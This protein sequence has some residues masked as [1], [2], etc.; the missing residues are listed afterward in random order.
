MKP[1]HPPS[2]KNIFHSLTL[3]L[4]FSVGLIVFLTVLGYAY[5]LLR[6]QENQALQKILS[7]AGMFSD[8]LRK[9]THY[10]MLKYQ[11][12]ALHK[13]IEAVGQ[14]SGVELIRIFNKKGA[15]MYSTRKQEVGQTVNMQAEA[16]YSCHQRD[17]ILERLPVNAR[18]RIFSSDNRGRVMGFINP[19]YNEASCSTAACHVHPADRTVLGVIDVVLSLSEVD[20]EIK[21]NSSNI[22]IF[23]LFFF[24][25]AFG[26]VGFCIFYFVDRPIGKLRLGTA[27]IASGDY[28]HPIEVHSTDEIG[29]LAL[30]FE[31]MRRKIRMT[32]SELRKSQREY[33]I[34]FESVPCYITVQDRNLRLLQTNREFRKDFGDKPGEHCYEV[35]KNRSD[36]CPNCS[37]ERTFQNGAIYTSEE[38]VT[39]KD[40]GQAHILVYTAPIYNEDKEI[41]SVMEVSVNITNLKLLEEELVKS[42]EAYRLLFN[43]DPSP[44]FVVQR[45]TFN[46]LDANTRALDLY[47]HDKSK[48]LKMTFMDL[49]PED[50]RDDLV[51]FF[52]EGKSFLGRLKQLRQEGSVFYVNLRASQ[53]VYRDTPVYII[54]TNDITERV[55]AEQQLAQ[56]SKMATLGEM[57]AGIAHELNQPLTVIKTGSNFILRKTRNKQP[58][59]EEILITLAE[60]MDAQ[61]DRASRIINHLREFGRKTE[62]HKTA[63]K[64]N[65]AIQGMLTVLKKQIELRQIR[66][67]LELDPGLPKILGDKNRLE[68][69]FINLAM[70]ARDALDDPRIKNKTIRIRSTYKNGRVQIEFS[71]NGCGMS[72]E[73]QDKIFEPFFTTKGVGQGTGLG[74]SISYGIIRDYEGKILVK[75]QVGEGTTFTL[76]F[77]PFREEGVIE[78]KP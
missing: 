63:V 51:S 22:L 38:T 64:P 11:P 45:D 56:A 29:D 66:L 28:S 76:L 18:S 77:P 54:T 47:G 57:S 62:I 36:K 48:L 20:R 70:N 49:A 34:L 53:G 72:K 27:E 58:L 1:W 21:K 60:E 23:A 35:Y 7:T 15:I 50:S 75:S 71:D 59:S 78:E 40:G 39:T 46:I 9:S 16:C 69:V 32:T 43:N 65:E 17:K 10:S 8:T 67:D 42:E 19:I 31:E 5:F 12:E 44:I 30:D 4:G 33:Q 61:V 3:R 73:I 41:A 26:L 24:L 55:Q 37:V 14:Q 13:I 52:R 2:L 6:T 74:L 68:Q 25:G